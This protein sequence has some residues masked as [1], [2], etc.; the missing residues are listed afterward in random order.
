ME[1]RVG[2]GQARSEEVCLLK[3]G[4]EWSGLDSIVFL[5]HGVAWLVLLQS[6]EKVRVGW[7][8]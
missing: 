6:G 2:T 5:R 7:A 1:W 3:D 4:W 8:R